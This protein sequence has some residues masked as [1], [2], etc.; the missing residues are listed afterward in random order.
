MLVFHLNKKL[1]CLQKLFLISW[2]YIIDN[3]IN[4][5]KVDTFKVFWCA[6]ISDINT[7]YNCTIDYNF[8]KSTPF[9]INIYVTN[10]A[11]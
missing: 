2:K 8:F 9:N 7:D 1:Q 4:W 10:T 6:G 3:F 5:C 11:N